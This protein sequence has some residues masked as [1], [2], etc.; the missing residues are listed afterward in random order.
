MLNLPPPYVVIEIVTVCICGW[1][2]IFLDDLFTHVLF[3]HNMNSLFESHSRINKIK[4]CPQ[5]FG[6]A[7]VHYFMEE[8]IDIC[9][10][11]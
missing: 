1:G 2:Q 3:Y 4:P 11:G 6:T 9:R 5:T 7:F 8:R 10:F